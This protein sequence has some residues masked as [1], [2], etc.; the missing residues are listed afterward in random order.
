MHP[1]I[2]TLLVQRGL[3]ERSSVE[4]FF[5]PGLKRIEA[6]PAMKDLAK[7]T[8][9]VLKALQNRERI[10]VYGDYDVDGSCAT[11]MVHSF[12]RGRGAEVQAYNPDRYKEG[13]GISKQGVS[14]AIEGGFGLVLALDCGIAAVDRI[15]ELAAGG[16]DCIVCDHHLPGPV[17]P[18][19]Y[20]ILNPK[21]RD[22]PL[23]G[24]ELCGCGVAFE[25]IRS[26]CGTLNLPKGEWMQFLPHVAVATCCDIV[27]LLGINRSLVSEGLKA[28]NA[29]PPPAYAALLRCAAYSG[30]LSVA[31]VVFKI[32]PRINA[33]GRLNHARKAVSLL[34]ATS[35]DEAMPMAM[36]LEQ[37][38]RERRSM[39]KHM[40]EEAVELM[41]QEDPH[42]NRAATVLSKEGWHKGLVGIAASRLMERCYR[43]TVVL[44]ELDGQLSGSA[45]SVEDFNLYK[46][47]QH[48]EEHLIQFGGHAAAAG[49]SLSKESFADF[50]A[51][52]EQYCASQL[53][54][55]EC[56]PPLRIDLKV[57]FREWANEQ[58]GIFF[59]QMNRLRPFGPGNMQ[60]VF[61]TEGC[62]AR[63]VR[64]LGADGSHLKF[65]AYQEDH[66]AKGFS[67]IAFGFGQL[68]EALKEGNRFDLAYTIGTNYWNGESLL[69]LEAKDII[70]S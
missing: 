24:E 56:I 48:C 16:I 15:S 35:L 60:A 45:R 51:A 59:K 14:H 1:I 49:M 57:D 65:E 32:G 69:Q 31:D 9:R 19:A 54:E 53:G 68:A 36:E 5:T 41:L 42:M 25:L 11:A 61:A 52:F 34:T 37:L 18:P 3:S 7:A 66:P 44:T 4:S 70:V 23:L 38:N 55:V 46:A 22:C 29:D 17:L 63:D 43:P 2:A 6:L 67:T 21:Q 10:L 64:V 28:L 12:L 50:K 62:K 39:D 33:A 20:A 8:E 30:T 27:P 13:Y 58:F 47:L 26:V 40:S